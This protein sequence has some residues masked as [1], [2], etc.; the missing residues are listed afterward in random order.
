MCED[1]LFK[2]ASTKYVQRWLLDLEFLQESIFR[3][4]GWMSQYL[5]IFII[6]PSVELMLEK[7][8]FKYV[9][10]ISLLITCNI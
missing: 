4:T 1:F 9:N 3:Q 8:H 7:N 5:V 10:F 6:C 2:Y